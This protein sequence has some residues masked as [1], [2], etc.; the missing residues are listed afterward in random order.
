MGKRV[1]L[2]EEQLGAVLKTMA[3]DVLGDEKRYPVNPQQVLIVKDFLDNTFEKGLMDNLDNS[4]MPCQ[5][6]IVIMKGPSGQE[7]KK[8]FKEDLEDLLNEKY[9]NMFKSDN[10]REKFIK[11]LVSDWFDEKISTYGLLSKNYV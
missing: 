7:I 2:N 8:M 11:Q 10:Q 1:I 6:Q 5:T 3:S 4:G 9:K